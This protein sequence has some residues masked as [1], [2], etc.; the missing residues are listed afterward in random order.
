MSRPAF[1]LAGEDLPKVL[2][3]FP[4]SGVLLLPR[5][6]IRLNIFEPR[7]LAMIEAALGAGRLIGMIQP[8]LPLPAPEAETTPPVIYGTGCAGRISSFSETD[9]GRFLIQLTGVARFHV[10]E[11]LEGVRGYR[12]IRP[13]W[14]RY[15]GDLEADGQDT[16][17]DREQLIET[18]RQ[19][20]VA[21]GI[22]A[23]W[24]VIKETPNERLVTSL[25][26]SCEFEA[27]EKQALL[28]SP[29]LGERCKMIVA[30][31]EMALMQRGGSSADRPRH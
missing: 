26:M 8:T 22:K 17:I 11:E 16:G 21:Q 9:D 12:R 14:E 24:K 20:F 3:I 31:M 4:L 5:G 6:S 29:T 27:N 1:A 18:L 25:A 2:S 10:A 7:Y 23:D 30:L 13:D 15:K 28:E 19:Y